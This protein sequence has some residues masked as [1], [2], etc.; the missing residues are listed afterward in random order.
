MTTTNDNA[1][2]KATIAQVRAARR[3]AFAEVSKML[4]AAYRGLMRDAGVGHPDK[5]ADREIRAHTLLN[6]PDFVARGVRFLAGQFAVRLIA[7]RASIEHTPRGPNP[8]DVFRGQ[9]TGRLLILQDE[10]LDGFSLHVGDL[11]SRA[12]AN[13]EGGL[14]AHIFNAL[15]EEAGVRGEAFDEDRWWLDV[16]RGIGDADYKGDVIRGFQAVFLDHKDEW[17]ACLRL[18]AGS[19]VLDLNPATIH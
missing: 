13:V 16:F 11:A 17:A 7:T 10:E 15:R 9:M 5:T 6:R 4:A 19:H 3:A 18:L 2:R 1:P 12:L 8:M 14:A